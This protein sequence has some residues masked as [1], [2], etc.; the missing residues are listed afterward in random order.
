MAWDPKRQHEGGYLKIDHRASP[1]LPE[2][3]ARLSGFD[4]SMAGEGKLLEASTLTCAHCK[5][6]VVK[7]PLRTRERAYCPKC[8]HYICDLCAARAYEPDYAHMPFE[9]FS[10][11]TQSGKEPLLN[12]PVPKG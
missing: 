5:C 11:L 4:P 1:G 3:I 8:D 7:N 6:A 12:S 9:K 2:D 10:D